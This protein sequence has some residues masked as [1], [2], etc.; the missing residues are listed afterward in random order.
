MRHFALPSQLDI[1][2]AETLRRELL[3]AAGTGPALLLEG[4][5][6]ERV[7]TA[8]LQLLASA[9]LGSPAT[10]CGV[11]GASDVLR[12]GAETL[13]LAALLQTPADPAA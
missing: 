11:S 2:N 4:S 10:A 13:G 7:D 1:R 12:E 3:A 5:A 9:L 8:G 6:V